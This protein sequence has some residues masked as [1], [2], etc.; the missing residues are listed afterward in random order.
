[1]NLHL[2]LPQGHCIRDFLA[3][4]TVP[5]LLELLPRATVVL[6]TPGHNVPRFLELCPSERVVVRR[7]EAPVR[8]APNVRLVRLRKA[9]RSRAIK[10]TLLAA[11]ARRFE[12]PG[13]LRETFEKH[14]PDL[15]VTT[16]P[17]VSYEYPP[18]LMARRLGVRTL[19]VVKSWDNLLKGLICR[20]DA[21][22][23]WNRTNEREALEHNGYRPD[24][25]TINGAISFDPYFR[26]EWHRDRGD[27][28]RGM[29]LDPG[30][31]VVTLATSG[32]Y[33]LQYVGRDETHLA[34]D[35][36]R[37]FETTPELRGAQLIV[38]LHVASRLENF[39]YLRERPDVAI[40][41]GK[42]MPAMGWYVDRDA[43]RE[44]TAI[45]QHSDAIVTPGSSWT[46][47]A[48]IFDTPTVVP[49]YSDLQPDHAREQFDGYT[50]SMHYRPIVERGWV[51]IARSFEETRRALVE[52]IT[53]PETY[54]Q[55]RREL[56]DAYVHFQ[57]GDSMERVA[58]WIA[59]HG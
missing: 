33:D 51:P 59:R 53:R 49:V 18:F 4:P 9:T 7:M 20:T 47:E 17:M 43:L 13:Y 39:L 35:L 11:E 14:P 5:R 37:M 57:D 34:D 27:F 21:L 45:L 16:H 12:P 50:L 6:L 54:R 1:M 38:R 55:A 36:L 40:S 42:F 22:S 41:H 10:R 15:L 48:A 28:L 24:E 58:R 31:P 8:A 32:V 44:Q 56:V 52:A 23:V 25:V 30:R 26:P 29:G 2:C 3:I 19:A 46:I